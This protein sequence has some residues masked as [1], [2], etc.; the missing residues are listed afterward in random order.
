VLTAPT[1]SI[2]IEKVIVSMAFSHVPRV[3]SRL[4][5]LTQ[6]AFVSQALLGFGL[7]LL[8]GQAEGQISLVNMTPCG[9]GSFPGTVCTIPATGGNHF[10]VI[11]FQ[12]GPSVNTSTTIS[13]ITDNVGNVYT[14]DSGA[15]SVDTAGGSMIDVWYVNNSIAGATSVTIT[16][17]A[18]VQNAGAVIWEY[19]GINPVTPLGQVAVL[20]SQSSSASPIG[21]PVTTTTPGE[22][23]L[24]LAASAG[25]LTG[26]DSGNE[27]N[28]DSSF[29]GMGWS[30]LFTSTTGTYTP[31][32]AQS[33]AGTY[34]AS[35]VSFNAENPLS[36]PDPCDLNGD[37]IVN[38]LDEQLAVG[39]SLGQTQCTANIDGASV[40]NVVIVQRVVNAATGGVCV[41]GNSHSVSLSW[42]AST[43]PN[44][45]G[46]NVYRGVTTGGPYTQLNSSLVPT[47][48]YTDSNVSPG[49]SYYYV[50]T[51]VNTGNLQSV[52][53]NEAQA[54]VP[55]P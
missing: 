50:T 2:T 51:A 27:F 20:N 11:G 53:S 54:T 41:T 8:C 7:V 23:V 30:N 31:Q 25:S 33:P 55:T 24:G 52:Y 39:M 22:L 46:Y 34:A 6:R 18:G 26:M 17:S 44:I 16:P 36:G 48:T 38:L 43:S 47:V 21:P 12:A 42:M 10:L 14:Q 1:D 13:S 35:T 49:Q 9:P 3:A 28:L 40:C 29:G 45:A 4:G 32:W 5:L 15:R 19:A 37:G